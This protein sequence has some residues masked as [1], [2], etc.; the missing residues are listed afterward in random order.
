MRKTAASKKHSTSKCYLKTQYFI[1]LTASK[2][3]QAR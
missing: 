1:D 3:I 2:N